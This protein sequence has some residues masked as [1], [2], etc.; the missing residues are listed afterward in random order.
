MTLDVQALEWKL[1]VPSLYRWLGIWSER[2]IDFG[3][4]ALQASFDM[5]VRLLHLALHHPEAAAYGYAELSAAALAVV[6]GVP[7]VKAATGMGIDM[8]LLDWLMSFLSSPS[9]QAL[10]LTVHSQSKKKRAQEA[11]PADLAGDLEFILGSLP[12]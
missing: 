11:L 10:A 3:S 9:L 1:S 12:A 2:T 8:A 5:A 4:P 6:I 7:A